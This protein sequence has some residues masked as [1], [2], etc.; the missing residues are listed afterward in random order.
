[1]PN[2][3]RHL[4]VFVRYDRPAR[5][6]DQLTRAALIVIRAVPLAR[7]AMLARLA[8]QRNLGED[9]MELHSGQPLRPTR[10]GTFAPSTGSTAY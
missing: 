4:N 3:N 2:I 7:D 9:K 5:Y 6:E 10:P 1:M 8:W